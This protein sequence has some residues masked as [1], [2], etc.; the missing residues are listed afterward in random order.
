QHDFPCGRKPHP[1]QGLRHDR[2]ALEVALMAAAQPVGGIPLTECRKDVPPGWSPGNP[3]YPLRLFF[4]KLKLWYRIYDGPDESVGPLVAGRL[5]GRAQKIAL[6][7]RLPRPDG[8]TDVGDAALVRLSV[9][10]V[11]DPANPM[12][13]LQNHVPSDIQA[14]ATALR[15]AFGQSD[16]ELTTQALEQFFELRRGKLDGNYSYWVE[17]PIMIGIIRGILKKVMYVKGAHVTLH[18]WA[19][20]FPE[21]H[22][23]AEQAPMR[24]MIV[25]E[26]KKW[27]M[28]PLE[29]LRELSPAQQR[30]KMDEENWMITFFGTRQEEEAAP[31]LAPA[32][33]PVQPAPQ[34]PPQEA[35]EP[36]AQPAP[37]EGVDMRAINARSIKPLYSVK[38]V[39]QRLPQAAKDDPLT[40]NKLLLG[41]H[42]KLWRATASDF[43]N[44]LM[45]AGMPP[46]VV[47]LASEAVAVCEVCRK[48]SRLPARPKTKV[49]L[50]AH[51]ND[52]TEMDIFYLWEKKF[53][54]MVD[55][56]T[57][58]KIAFETPSREAGD[59]RKGILQHWIR[60]FG[61]MR[62]LTL[63]QERKHTGT[64]LV[65]RHVG[66]TK[67]TMLKIRSEI[68]RQ[69]MV[70]EDADI[71]MEAAMS[72]N[73][74]LTYGGYTPSMA[75]F[76]VLPRAFFEFETSQLTAIMGAADTNLTVFESAM[77][78]RQ[79]ALTA[80]CRGST[81]VEIYR[82]SWK[83]P[84]ALL[85]IDED[86]GTAIV[87]HQGKPYP[88]PIRFVRPYK[89]TFYALDENSGE[90]LYEFM[91]CVE[92]CQQYKQNY[93]GSKPFIT[94][95]GQQWRTIPEH[96]HALQARFIRLEHPVR[97]VLYGQAMKMVHVP[98]NTMGTV[99]TWSKGTSDYSRAA[100]N[101]DLTL[102]MKEE[103]Q[104]RWENL[105]VI[106]F[107]HFVVP[108][109]FTEP[110]TK[111]V[112]RA[113]P[114]TMDV[115]QN[116]PEKKRIRVE[117]Y[118]DVTT[119]YQNICTFLST[120]EEDTITEGDLPEI[121]PEVRL[122]DLPTDTVIIDGTWIRRWKIKFD[123]IRELL[124]QQGIK[125]PVRSVVMIPP[126]NTWRHLA[127]VEPSFLYGLNDA[128]VAWQL[129][130]GSFLKKQKGTPSHL[131]DSFYFW[132][133]SNTS[134][135]LSGALTTHVDDLA[136]TGDVNFKD[137]LY[138]AMTKEFGKLSR[139]NLPFTHCG[140][141]Y[142]ATAT[143]LKMDQSDFAKRPKPAP[144][145]TG[146]DDRD[147][148]P[149]ELTAFRSVLGGLLWLCSTRLDIIAE[150]G[151]LQ[152][153]VR[154][155]KV[156]R[157]KMANALV[158]KAT[159]N[160]NHT[161]G[162]HYRYVKSKRWRTQC[163]HDA[164]S[165]SQGR[166][167]AQEG[168]IVL[169]T[170]ELPQDIL[171]QD[172]VCENSDAARLC[173]YGHVLYAQG[174]KAK[175]VSYSTSHAE[176]LAAVAG[177]EASSMVS[178]RL[179]EL[180]LPEPAPTL[181]K[182]TY[183]QENGSGMFPI[184]TATDCRDFFE[185]VTGSKSLPQDKFQ[186]LYVLSFKE[187]R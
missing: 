152:S 162:L 161:L 91:R 24:L 147:L 30:Q 38:R 67:L 93:L 158:K 80:H 166:H 69:G 50:A 183:L 186:R 143:G 104:D 41:L 47:Q 74:C 32:S 94:S 40:A 54:L 182:L 179:T 84:A 58:Y 87:K 132:K 78:L 118:N 26:Y 65:E 71:A 2:L 116:A 22:F 59:L 81:E 139:Q 19:K 76:G 53:V 57:R 134:H 103:H 33:V 42:E 98:Q 88:T 121:W 145:P 177:L 96:P 61:P 168:V 97:A 130:L 148:Q 11:R 150:V 124:P 43:A 4:E 89:G 175:R 163:I 159:E 16:Q 140:A 126:R 154:Q 171:N 99:L 34:Q 107:L 100:K 9:D 108:E 114:E 45:R 125:T 112:I 35:Q 15:E 73:L 55:V 137:P 92:E 138:K 176:T 149:A 153:A 117:Y 12:V 111:P 29:D 82:D 68:Q 167:Y 6:S 21:P 95:E 62:V 85:E 27:V 17:D 136:V 1:G 36:Q 37:Y 133:D 77:R 155:A 128:P 151:I 113:P 115:E 3:D 146:N 122:S 169:L 83:G 178:T 39:L 174:S 141:L 10:E 187:A 8:Q 180:W 20:V 172:V 144:V 110:L 142:S 123:K 135:G 127:A 75:L 157:I 70:I 13:V 109:E 52:E 28:M 25:G 7:L 181:A 79:I 51:F 170:P 160:G 5:G 119:E 56:A 14:L 105:C 173:N 131:D 185:L 165:A 23:P 164:S 46:E 184:D 102:R 86:E 31:A 64:G 90:L 106:Y 156:K 129:S 48:Y 72:H 49:S 60:H 44:L 63:D 120:S 18:P 66:L 101:D